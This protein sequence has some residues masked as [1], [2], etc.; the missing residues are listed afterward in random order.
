MSDQI[1][2]PIKLTDAQ[3]EQLRRVTQEGATNFP[4]G[5]DLIYRWIKDNPAAQ[6][7]GTV[8][9]FEQA[10]GINGDD[11]VSARFIRRHTDNGLDAAGV[12]HSQRLEMQ[13][14][15]NR[16]AGR[17]T[18]DV[19]DTGG[20]AALPEIVNKD[21]SVALDD[22]RVKLGGWGGSFYYWDMPFKTKDD[23]EYPRHPDGSYKTLGDEITRLGQV[24]LL[25]ETSSR[26]V[27][28]MQMAGELPAKEWGTALQTGLDAG[29]PMRYQAEIGARAAGIVASETAERS[30][31]GALDRIGEFLHEVKCEA[32]P[33]LPD[34][35]PDGASLDKPR[36]I[37]DPRDPMSPDYLLHKQIETG[38]A[39][40]DADRG[41]ESDGLSARLTM[42]S[43]ED[44]KLSGVCS[45]DHV[46]LNE[47]GRK[48]REDGS[49]VAANTSLIVIEGKDPYD[50]SAKRAVTEVA[51][52]VGIPVEQSAQRIEALNQQQA[53]LL[54][55]QPTAPTQDGPSHGSRTM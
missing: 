34:C 2:D 11:S 28:Q 31:E 6:Q 41:R 8:F 3:I 16:I 22:G 49:Y 12:P 17:V 33:K 21:I 26:T 50:P 48:P 46:V 42:K 38:V 55:Q 37:S 27:A 14:L 5:Y 47:A 35:P 51:P 52:A 40:I 45:A 9:W 7:D 44:C 39:R 43:L 15:S 30:K 29:I 23:K 25:I 53:Q 54:A 18:K 24:D 1:R 32:W 10:R 36:G 4:A 13:E 20:V 19:I